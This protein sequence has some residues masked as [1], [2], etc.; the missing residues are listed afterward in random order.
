MR[1]CPELKPDVRPSN[2]KSN[3]V[4]VAEIHRRAAA[5]SKLKA[6]LKRYYKTEWERI[7]NA[8]SDSSTQPSSS[9][10]PKDLESYFTTYAALTT[11][12]NN[13]YKLSKMWIMDSGTDTHV[14]NNSANFNKTRG[15]EGSVVYAGKT[16]YLIEAFGT[17]KIDVETR[18]GNCAITLLNCRSRSWLHNQ[19]SVTSSPE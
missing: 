3:K 8:T 18:E 9:T 17:C 1:S 16:S 13:D 12:G 11:S 15:A 2:W 4:A 6:V 14:C 5:S 19:L 10:Q 7:R